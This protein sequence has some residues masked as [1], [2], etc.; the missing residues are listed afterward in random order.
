MRQP[1]PFLSNIQEWMEVFMHHSMRNFLLFAKETGVSMPQIGAMFHIR[2]RGACGVSAVGDELGVTSAAAS[3]ML[4]R[5][6]QQ[7]L[8][9]RSED[10][11]DRRNKQ[12]VLTEKGHALLQ[13]SVRARQDWLRELDGLLTPAESE[14]VNQALEILIIKTRQLEQQPTAILLKE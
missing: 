14:L 8:I 12:I 2:Q 3:Q 7:K 11:S 13:Q 4:D 5:L 6:V 9:E 1:S 10:P